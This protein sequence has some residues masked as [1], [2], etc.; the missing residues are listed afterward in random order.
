MTISPSALWISRSLLFFVTMATILGWAAQPV[1]AAQ[2]GLVLHTDSHW[3][4]HLATRERPLYQ[5][6]EGSLF[7]FHRQLDRVAG[8][9]DVGHSISLPE[10]ESEWAQADFDDQGWTWHMG[11]LFPGRSHAIGHGQ[12]EPADA[13]HLLVRGRFGLRD[14]DSAR[15]LV[16]SVRYRGGIAIYLNG[17]EIERRHLPEGPIGETMLATAYTA[18]QIGPNPDNEQ[19]AEDAANRRLRSIERVTLPAALMRPG[20]NILAFHLVAAPLPVEAAERHS[21]RNR[22][23][24]VGLQEVKLS[25]GSPAAAAAFL[26]NVA[27][28]DGVQVWT[29]QTIDDIGQV[30]RYGDP[31]ELSEGIR[32]IRLAA[33]RNMVISGQA[34]VSA[35]KP[36]ADIAAQVSPFTGDRGTLRLPAEAV[37]V[38]Y[39]ART[40]EGM[41]YRMDRPDVLLDRPTGHEPLQP[42]WLTVRI[43]ADATPGTWRATLTIT[44]EGLPRPVE[45][46][47]EL[48]IHDWDCPEPQAWRSMVSM[49]HSPHSVA[50]HHGV[51]MWS[52]RHL[53]LL[54][55]SLRMLRDL[56]NNVVY[57]DVIHPSF[58]GNEHGII[59]FRRANDR[60]VPDF[61]YFDR[62]LDA[63]AR[64]VGEPRRINLVM[65][66]PYVERDGITISVRSGDGSLEHVNVGRYG[67]ARHREMW[68]AM[69]NGV[70]ERV[71]ARGWDERAIMLGVG[72]DRRPSGAIVDFFN[73]IAPYARWMLFTHG[74][75]DPQIRDGQVSF[76]NMKV[77][78][79]EYPYY[80][81][82]RA[83]RIHNGILHGW[84]NDWYDSMIIW[85]GRMMLNDNSSP[86]QFRLFANAG[87]LG[88]SNGFCRQGIDKWPVVNP[89][90]PD[91]GPRRMV[92]GTGGWGNLYRHKVRALAAPGP[93]GA[94]ATVRFELMREGLQET[95]TRIYLERAIVDSEKQE[96]IGD[97]IAAQVRR[98]NQLDWEARESLP[99]N[100][101]TPGTD[102]QHRY[103]QRLELAAEVQRRLRAAELE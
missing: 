96:V 45:V 29:T 3:R 58:F 13:S 57:I 70:H 44:A 60:L 81:H 33:A 49:V 93:E 82:G 97:E 66:E 83:G 15:D 36:V 78:L 5:D 65:W 100:T 6:G 28:P 89:H 7:T 8:V 38:R 99:G 12:G 25:A 79:Q 19:Q 63:Y 59:V 23:A 85:A 32:P 37:Q 22:W 35:P 40:I 26:S 1:S 42:V 52:D 76:G 51:E 69:M 91:A 94:L 92:H 64:E 95:E 4:Y 90:R 98:I 74:R 71:T 2:E 30:I 102:W 18:E 10:G 80:A 46:P 61:T 68:K 16:L 21:Y 9:E 75:G 54:R 72:H 87:V 101:I 88:R 41:S 67:D 84:V 77:G 11:P 53:E 17:H 56:G 43:P 20:T 62:F 14:E 55:P 86:A 39:P 31:V 34:I 24:T 50:W 48:V 27:Q 103:E 73:E 47:V